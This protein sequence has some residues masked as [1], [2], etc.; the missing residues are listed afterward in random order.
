MILMGPFQLGV[1]YDS[2]IP[3]PRSGWMRVACTEGTKQ[4]EGKI[5]SLSKGRWQ[6]VARWRVLGDAC[7]E[8][9][10]DNMEW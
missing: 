6:W 9:Q 2:S 1:F 3:Y 4:W 7:L 10:E 5:T 8:K